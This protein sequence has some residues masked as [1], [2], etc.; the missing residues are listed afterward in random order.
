MNPKYIFLIFGF[1]FSFQSAWSQ[2]SADFGRFRIEL[3]G[4]AAVPVGAFANNSTDNLTRP[5]EYENESQY[6]GVFT[7][8]GNGFAKPGLF[9]GGEITY[10]LTQSFF[11]GVTA[12]AISNPLDLNT[13]NEFL[14]GL[15]GN[16]SVPL[17]FNM[18]QED[19]KSTFLA[20]IIG[21]QKIKGQWDFRISQAVG[22]SRMDF[23][24]FE[25]E[26]LGP[27]V[28][29]FFRHFYATE[30]LTSW[31]SK[32]ESSFCYH[33]TE[34]F[35]V[36]GSI[37]YLFSDFDYDLTLVISPGGSAEWRSPDTVNMRL[38]NFGFHVGFDF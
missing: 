17:K 23:P 9:Y 18:S 25:M 14:V 26:I 22:F 13:V 37:A 3:K 28:P 27:G 12:L 15:E 32:T 6:I 31:F 38:L 5:D 36:G 16:Y 34:R 29:L 20:P 11:V 33:L 7:K 30:D 4:G 35:H 8:E 1:L 2:E 24:F 19:Y 10:N 21:F